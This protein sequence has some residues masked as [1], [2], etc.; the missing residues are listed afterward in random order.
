VA[1]VI[2]GHICFHVIDPDHHRLSER[3]KAAQELIDVIE[4]Y[5]K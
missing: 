1:E 4:V 3:A 2:E 5:M